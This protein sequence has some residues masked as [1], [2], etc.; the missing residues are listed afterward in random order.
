MVEAIKKYAGKLAKFNVKV[1]GVTLTAI[2]VV[3]WATQEV[4]E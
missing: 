1:I 3:L 2:G 4:K